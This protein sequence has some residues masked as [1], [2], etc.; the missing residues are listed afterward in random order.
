MLLGWQDS[1]LQV[2]LLLLFGAV[3]LGV[4]LAVVFGP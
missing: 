2:V 3:L 4:L 1:L